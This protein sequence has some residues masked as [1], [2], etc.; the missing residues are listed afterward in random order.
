MNLKP[1]FVKEH[2][3]AARART[4]VFAALGVIS[5]IVLIILILS[6]YPFSLGL[7]R[8]ARRRPAMFS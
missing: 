2:E 5:F 7:A 8:N 4:I 6:L 3:R 1:D